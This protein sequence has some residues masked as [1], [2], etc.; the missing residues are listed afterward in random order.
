M[1]KKFVNLNKIACGTPHGAFLT[2]AP[3]GFTGA[4]SLK[5]RGVPAQ[6]VPGGEPVRG[7]TLRAE[8]AAGGY[9][10]HGAEKL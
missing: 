1:Y 6:S 7:G 9:V 4:A 10:W 5:G 3:V 2:A 8:E